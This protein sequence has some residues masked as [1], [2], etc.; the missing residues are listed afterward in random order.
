MQ[1][2]RSQLVRYG[3]NCRHCAAYDSKSQIRSCGW[4][5]VRFTRQVT[6]GVAGVERSETPVVAI[7]VAAVERS[8]PPVV[9]IGVAGVER[10]ESPVG[11]LSGI[12]RRLDPSHPMQLYERFQI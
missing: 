7:G 11:S 6:H 3:G 9:A 12:E 10:S 4:G 8:E 1:S 2:H 5:R